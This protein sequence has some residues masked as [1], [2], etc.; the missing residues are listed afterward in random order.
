[1]PICFPFQRS[2][3]RKRK[4]EPQKLLL[5]LANTMAVFNRQNFKTLPNN[6]DDNNFTTCISYT[7]H[8]VFGKGIHLHQH[9]SIHSALPYL[10]LQ[11]ALAFIISKLIYFLLRP[12]KQPKFVCNILVCL[13]SLVYSWSFW[14]FICMSWYNYYYNSLECRSLD[15]PTLFRDKFLGWS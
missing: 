2:S 14:S 13:I 7:N 10:M 6:K 4:I 8:T 5:I 12:L 1:M 9:N 15:W 11:L 3:S